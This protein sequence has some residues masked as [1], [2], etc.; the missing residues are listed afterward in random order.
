LVG[1]ENSISILEVLRNKNVV[2]EYAD[3]RLGDHICYYTDN[4]KFKMIIK[5]GNQHVDSTNF[6][7]ITEILCCC[8]YL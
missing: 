7:R 4:T 2:V 1:K 6:E 8:S 3:A 5:L